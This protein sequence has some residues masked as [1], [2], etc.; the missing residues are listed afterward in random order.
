MWEVKQ[1]YGVEG[2]LVVVRMLEY[3]GMYHAVVELDALYDPTRG[4]YFQ[5]RCDILYR[6]DYDLAMWYSEST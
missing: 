5:D 4:I 1:L 2:N 3:P 6:L